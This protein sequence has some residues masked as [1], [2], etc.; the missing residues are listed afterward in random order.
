MT[1]RRTFLATLPAA[2]LALTVARTAAAQAAKL[3]ESDSMAV[4]L[5]Y[6]HDASKVDT[7]KFTTYA[8]GRNC[9]NCQF[10]QGKATDAWA[11]CPAVGGKLVNAKGWCSAWVKKA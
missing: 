10:Y 6:K 3:E 4:S 2:T 11:L 9:A 1:T 8:A 7:K 5:G